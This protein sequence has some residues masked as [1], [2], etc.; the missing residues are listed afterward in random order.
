MKHLVD[1]H[2]NFFYILI[3]GNAIDLYR[4][5]KFIVANPIQ[6]VW[7]LNFAFLVPVLKLYNLPTPF[8]VPIKIR[9]PR[10]QKF[11]NLQ[12]LLNH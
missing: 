9:N 8:C 11:E 6:T 4:V 5:I 12:E 10:H 2:Y 7:S 3:K 1:F